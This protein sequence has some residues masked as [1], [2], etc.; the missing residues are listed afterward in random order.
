MQIDKTIVHHIVK[1]NLVITRNK[2]LV[3]MQQ[4]GSE[5]HYAEQ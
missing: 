1:Y 3:H 5:R 4:D 2:I